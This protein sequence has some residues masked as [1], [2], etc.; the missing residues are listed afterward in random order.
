MKA[1]AWDD[2]IQRQAERCAAAAPSG[3][4]FVSLDE[5]R[6]SFPP[7]TSPTLVRTS[8]Q[9]MVAMGLA[10]RYEAGALLWWNADYAHYHFFKQHPGYDFYVF[11]EYDALFT[12]N[13]DLL[14]TQLASA[15]ADFAAFPL[16]DSKATWHWTKPHLAVYPDD[17]D[18]CLMSVCAFSRRALAMLYRRRLE[19]SAQPQVPYWPSAEAFLPTESKRAGL[20]SVSLASF[21][22]T[23]H[24]DWHPPCLEQIATR[25]P[26]P[27]FVHPVYDRKRYIQWAIG[28]GLTLRSLRDPNGPILSARSHLSLGAYL[29]LYASAA[30]TLLSRAA[31][32]RALG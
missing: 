14:V 7:V 28:K 22:D 19:M 27:A 16:R 9:A 23:T 12:G 2:F 29:P 5:T 26:R 25:V 1:F 21:G 3:H 8:E 30:A 32:R 20:N 31:T 15:G 18:G 10:A 24:F 4:F 6:A 13:L 11:I 17:L